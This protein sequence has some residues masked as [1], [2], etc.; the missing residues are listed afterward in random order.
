[1]VIYICSQH[2]TAKMDRHH[3]WTAANYHKAYRFRNRVEVVESV[4]SECIKAA[5]RSLYEL[6]EKPCPTNIARNAISDSVVTK[7]AP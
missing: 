7:S 3:E 1:V 2:K 4:C 6:L 5:R